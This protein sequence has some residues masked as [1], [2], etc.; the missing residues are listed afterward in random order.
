MEFHN[1]SQPVSNTGPDPN[2]FSP[3]EFFIRYSKYL[4]WLLVSVV[5]FVL[6]AFIRLRYSTEIYEVSGKIL[7]KNQ[8]SRLRSDDFESIFRG[9]GTDNL[10]DEIEQIKSTSIARR[11]V[12]QYGLGTMYRNKGSIKSTL[13]HRN[14]SPVIFQPLNVTDSVPFF[15]LQFKIETETTFSIKDRRDTL[16]FGQNI[17]HGEIIFRLLRTDVPLQQFASKEFDIQWVPDNIA[18]KQLAE[19]LT[20]AVVTDYSNVLG[21]R[22]ETENPKIGKEIIDG[23]M[24]AYQDANLEDKRRTAVNALSFIDEQLD[25]LQ[26]ELGGVERRLQQYRERNKVID[27]DAQSSLYLNSYSEAQTQI[28][29]LEVKNRVV[30]SLIRYL[31]QDQNQFRTVP[32]S[33]GIPEPAMV[34][35]INE[36]NQAQLRREVL[37]QSTPERNP[38]VTD[39]NV[40]IETLRQDILATLANVKKG[41]DVSLSDLRS[42]SGERSQDL[43]LIPGKQKQ[44]LEITRQQK[45][46]EELYSLLLQKKLETSISSASTI[47][48]SK[49]VEPADSSNTPVKPN[50]KVLYLLAALLGLAVPVAAIGIRELFNDKVSS[51]ADIEKST[52]VPVLGE[53]GHAELSSAL[54]MRGNNRS[55]IAE[56]FR[57]LRSNLQ[58]FIPKDEKPVILV[59]SSFSAEGKSFI[60]TNLGAALAISGKK[61]VILEF[62]IRKPKILKGLGLTENKGITNYLVGGEEIETL[63]RPVPQLENLYV[64]ACGPIPPN[65][66]ELL[67]EPRVRGVFEFAKNNFDAVIIDTAPAGMISDAI[68]LGQYANTAIYIV[69][70]NH[71]FKRQIKFIQDLYV[72]QKLP[73]LSIVINDVEKGKYSGSYGYG[74]GYGYGYES[75]Y[76]ETGAERKKK[77]YKRTEKV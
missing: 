61:T 73:K 58:F 19:R 14:N 26:R 18:A 32:S 45:I 3:R 46:L 27:V 33:L 5:I 48:S 72:Q 16:S 29:D 41:Y 11:V 17:K 21:I 54:I 77:W 20:V 52:T 4:P 68:T 75:H 44:L 56:Q 66:S 13:I 34:N 57:I 59:T 64:I 30:E 67:L 62:D 2:Q 35:L 70:H 74:Y 37:L 38:V 8:S 42:R 43:S 50:R 39:L 23:T 25:T 24:A 22:M 10:K 7:I 76:F 12:K 49:I 1:G 40:A 65:P 55:Y 9:E 36:Y 60:S 71:T 15:Q 53:I 69:R 28:T 6:L 63:P 31:D 51:K 47:F